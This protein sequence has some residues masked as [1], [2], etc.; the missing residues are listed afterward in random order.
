[1]KLKL[2]VCSVLLLSSCANVTPSNRTVVNT[3]QEKFEFSAT[4]KI[5]AMEKSLEFV[6]LV[7]RKHPKSRFLIEYQTNESSFIDEFV[8]KIN[9]MGINKLRY[10]L[11]VMLVPQE[12]SIRLIATYYE[13]YDK[14]C[15]YASINNIDT[16]SFGCAVEYNRRLSLSNPINSR[17]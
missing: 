11:M 9:R 6:D 12:K 10:K 14:N 8:A 15:G 17:E 3:V 4:N 13:L 2:L 1:M 16:Y 7:N 5:K